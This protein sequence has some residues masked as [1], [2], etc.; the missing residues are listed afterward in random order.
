MLGV[1]TDMNRL[2][3]RENVRVTETDGGRLADL[4]SRHAAEAIRLA[5]MLT[6]DRVL[7]EDLVQDAFVKLAGHLVHLRD[8]GA[9]DAYLRRTIV[10][11][12]NSYFRRKRTE[13][14]YLARTAAE[15]RLPQD[16]PDISRRDELWT[17][18]QQLP[19]R[20]RTAIVLRIYEDLPEQRVAEILACRPG[21]VRSLVSRGLA[22]LRI[23]VRS[24]SDE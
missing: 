6:G 7:A 24:E 23:H 14:A 3:T 22:E 21:T 19:A 15:P 10:N 11:Q 17:R 1:L 8:P 12:T 5:Y 2:G 13:R 20:Q 4:Y 16:A 18:L 9:F